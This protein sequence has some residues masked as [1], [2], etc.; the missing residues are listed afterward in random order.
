MTEFLSKLTQEIATP[1]PS[2]L[3]WEILTPN[4]VDQGGAGGGAWGWGWVVRGKG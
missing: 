2:V 1:L 3:N 4:L